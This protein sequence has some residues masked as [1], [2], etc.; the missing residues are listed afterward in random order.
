MI[1]DNQHYCSESRTPN[2]ID[3]QSGFQTKEKIIIRLQQ[4]TASLLHRV[5]VDLVH[6]LPLM[7]RH[8]DMIDCSKEIIHIKHG[9]VCILPK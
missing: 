3:G 2:K 7:L 9:H 8:G 5:Q 6:G 4:P 1:S